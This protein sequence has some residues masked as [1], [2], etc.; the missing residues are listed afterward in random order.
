MRARS[1]LTQLTSKSVYD[2]KH[3]D[4]VFNEGDIVLAKWH[5][6]SDKASFISL[7]LLPKWEGPFL[8]EKRISDTTY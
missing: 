5:P 6:K 8:I 3:R 1:V 7:K 2:R 4:I